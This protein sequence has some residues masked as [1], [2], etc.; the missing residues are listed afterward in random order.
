MSNDIIQPI[1]KE[2]E[3]LL[4]TLN[5]E[6][7]ENLAGLKK[8]SNLSDIYKSHSSLV[9]PA[10]FSSVKDISP[11]DKE[12]ERGLKLILNFLARSVIG[13]KTARV[14]DEMLAT[15]LRE[16][17]LIDGKAIPYRATIA[18]I[19]KEPRRTRR[20]ELDRKR[21][22]KVLKLNPL[23][24][25]IM[26]IMHS[27]SAELGFPSFMSLCDEAEMLNLRK[28]EEKAK[29]FL[30]DTEYVYRDLLKWFLLKRMELQLKDAKSYDLY[31]LFNSFELKAN[32]PQRD[33]KA[34]AKTFLDEMGIEIGE[35]I[36]TDLEQRRGKISRSF[37]MP[38]QVPE[39]I[40]L[41]IYPVG[42][43]E[44]YESFSHEIGI[45]LSYGHAERE[46]EFEF[47]RLRESASL[48]TFGILFR[49]LLIQPKWQRKYLKLDTSTD[50]LK[51]LY[52]KQ[53]M[54]IRYY[55]GK[56]IYEPALH[57]DEDFKSKSDFYKQTLEKATLCEHDEADYLNDVDQFF[58]SA[59]YLKA[60]IIEAELKTYLREN[61]DE[62]WWREKGAG[63]F[64]SRLWKEGGRTTS[65]E[66][67]KKAGFEEL[68][69]KP[70][71]QFFREVFG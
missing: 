43:I 66:I 5:R 8:V 61:F 28:L 65:E 20:E 38:I 32:F 42:G 51:F 59:S 35:N 18:E 49:S 47:R 6:L 69:S 57:S 68:D 27:T 56:L 70:L 22:E 3:K 48:E 45:S 19:K 15:E 62:E 52:L 41:V 29:L 2:G 40:V 13:S 4:R 25:K 17:I 23:I 64:I 46:D 14:R 67:A 24:L 39:N 34:L 26:D 71:F 36:K 30:S 60:F 33:L 7:Y 10:L 58:H 54:A 11:K 21:R 55:S 16:E 63:D 50:F 12:E 44:D 31:Y 9:D 53:L 37:S 1:R